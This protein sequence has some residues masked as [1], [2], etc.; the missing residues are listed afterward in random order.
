ME[1]V[2]EALDVRH[3]GK[4][5]RTLL[6]NLQVSQRMNNVGNWIK[7]VYSESASYIYKKWIKTLISKTGNLDISGHAVPWCVSQSR[8]RA[9]AARIIMRYDMDAPTRGQDPFCCALGGSLELP[10]WIPDGLVHLP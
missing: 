9:N 2:V 5:L 8:L 10:T 4:V 1:G 7:P 3:V 6:S